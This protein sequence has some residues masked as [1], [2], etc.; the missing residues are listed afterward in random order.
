M[1]GTEREGRTTWEWTHISVLGADGILYATRRE[2]EMQTFTTY[3][4]GRDELVDLTRLDTTD[5]V[6]SLERNRING[7]AVG[8]ST[9]FGRTL[10]IDLNGLATVRSTHPRRSMIPPPKPAPTQIPQ[11][12]PRSVAAPRY[13]SSQPPS[14]WRWPSGS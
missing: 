10:L 3:Q 6:F 14:H 2:E 9:D 13:S 11:P 1:Q 5:A 12:K 4:I 7:E 8:G